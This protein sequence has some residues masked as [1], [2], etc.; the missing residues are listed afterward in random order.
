MRET[1]KKYNKKMRFMHWLV[2]LIVLGMLA[3][4]FTMDGYPLEIKRTAYGLHKS[5]G[6]TLFF[7][8]L[9]RIAIRLKSKIPPAPRAI[10]KNQQLA[11]KWAHYFLYVLLLV[12]TISGYT[13]SS[14]GGHGVK[15]FGI[16]TTQWLPLDKDLSK[17]A[18]TI[19]GTTAFLLAGLIA[20]HLLG[21]LKHH[22]LD[23]IPVLKRML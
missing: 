15:W 12:M 23:K 16:E 20:L 6:L 19:H 11:A 9:I 3:V 10:P 2:A 22:W 18:Y 7:L 14:A 8:V 4:G 5:F 1:L 13:M 17:I 21:T